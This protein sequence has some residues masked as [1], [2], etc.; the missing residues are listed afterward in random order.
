[1]SDKLMSKKKPFFPITKD[2]NDYLTFYNRNLEIPI[3]Y[4]DLK[5]IFRICC[6]LQ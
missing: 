4:E 3:F 6:S 1:M 5:K 2:L